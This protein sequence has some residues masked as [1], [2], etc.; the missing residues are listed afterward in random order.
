MS[1]AASF[2]SRLRLSSATRSLP[3]RA[4]AVIS[5]ASRVK[6]SPRAALS[7]SGVYPADVPTSSQLAPVAEV[8]VVISL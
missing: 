5:P 7:L 3:G 1:S 2:L 4:A 6:A 8:A